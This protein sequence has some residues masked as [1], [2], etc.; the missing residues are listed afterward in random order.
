MVI[1]ARK[2]NFP[3][4]QLLTG[5]SAGVEP[6][7]TNHYTRRFK[8]SDITNEEIIKRIEEAEEK[9]KR[10][11]IPKISPLRTQDGRPKYTVLDEDD[12]Y[13]D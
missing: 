3:P 9:N 7:I 1:Y 12:G 11:E 8:M 10:G 6:L 5:L 4:I 2:P 13:H